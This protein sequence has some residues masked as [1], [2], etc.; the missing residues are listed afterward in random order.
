M[1]RLINE[2]EPAAAALSMEWLAGNYMSL[3]HASALRMVRNEDLADDITQAVFTILAKKGKTIPPAAFPGWLVRATRYCAANAKRADLRRQHHERMAARL[4][5]NPAAPADQTNEQFMAALEEAIKTLQESDQE[6]VLLRFREG[7]KFADVAAM[8]GISEAAA[9]QRLSRALKRLRKYFEDHQIHIGSEALLVALIALPQKGSTYLLP[10]IAAAAMG[11]GVGTSAAV[12]AGGAVVLGGSGALVANS[13]ARRTEKISTEPPFAGRW[14]GMWDKRWPV[15][16][17]IT[18]N[19]WNE[20]VT[21]VYEWEG[22][23][24]QPMWRHQLA[25]NLKGNVLRA[26]ETIEILLCDVRAG[27][28]KAIGYFSRQLTADLVRN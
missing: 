1:N 21:V 20:E 2:N 7:R 28:A 19:P 23:P 12:L 25:G 9:R 4:E 10:M 15:H 8:L 26:G 22:A 16:F 13:L 18:Q 11:K 3:V 17:T 27:R 6:A 5:E 24:D 14:T